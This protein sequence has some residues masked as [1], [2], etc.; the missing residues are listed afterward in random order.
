M[1]STTEIMNL[2]KICFISFGYE[3]LGMCHCFDFH[4]LHKSLQESLDEFLKENRV[5]GYGEAYILLSP[6]T[7][8]IIRMA[9]GCFQ[10][11]LSERIFKGSL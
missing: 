9:F 2:K 5:K 6:S 1:P 4:S 11:S 10:M 3:D 8:R 7:E